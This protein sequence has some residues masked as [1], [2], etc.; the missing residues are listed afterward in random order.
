MPRRWRALLSRQGPRTAAVPA[1]QAGSPTAAA[2]LPSASV[3]LCQ[4]LL[5]SP[6]MPGTWRRPDGTVP[7][8]MIVYVA[9]PVKLPLPADGGGDEQGAPHPPDH[10]GRLSP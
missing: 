8:P 6:A 9:V 7:P 1:A 4:A 10:R 5:V 2:L 3:P